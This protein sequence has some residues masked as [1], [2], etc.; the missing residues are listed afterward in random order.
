MNYQ[1]I[2][3][4]NTA[5]KPFTEQELDADTLCIDQH[6]HQ[7]VIHN[8]D[9]NTFDHVIDCLMYI[10][11]HEPIQAEQCTMIIHYK[12]KCAVK[13]DALDKLKPMHQALLDQGLSAEI[14]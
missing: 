9:F 14:K 11:G 10:C 3:P 2:K 12:G 8:D 7:L 5:T 1:P 13:T 6:Q 4:L